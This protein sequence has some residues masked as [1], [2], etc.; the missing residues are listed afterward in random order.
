MKR[1]FFERYPDW[2][3][4]PQRELDVQIEP[5]EDAAGI[6]ELLF[7]DLQ[8]ELE[9]FGAIRSELGLNGAEPL[10]RSE[11]FSLMK[12]LSETEARELLGCE[13]EPPGREER[14]RGQVNS[15]PRSVNP[16]ERISLG[17]IGGSV[18]HYVVIYAPEG[19]LAV[20]K[21]HLD[22]VR[23]R[24]CCSEGEA[25][26]AV[27]CKEVPSFQHFRANLQ[28]GNPSRLNRITLEIDPT[29]NGNDVKRLYDSLRKRLSVHYKP[30]EAKSI[31][32]ATWF[33]SSEV[34]HLSSEEKLTAWNE[35]AE[36][37]GDLPLYRYFSELERRARTTKQRLLDPQN[38]QKT[39]E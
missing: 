29:L 4:P 15:G 10:D 37:V 1:Y 12:S 22:Y 18:L 8:Y 35:H 5:S 38:R 34:S 14:L 33:F 7:Q 17:G 31:R 11:A 6:A 3:H 25:V 16:S 32:V 36:A 39:D 27:L 23:G 20:F 28:F 13:P 9:G 21:R 2:E 26:L 19:R 30:P 24:M